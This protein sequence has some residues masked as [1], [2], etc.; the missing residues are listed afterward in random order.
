MSLGRAAILGASVNWAGALTG[1]VV[2]FLVNAALARMIEPSSFASFALATVYS[3]LLSIVV[4]AGFAHAIVQLEERPDLTVPASLQCNLVAG[5]LLIIGSLLLFPIVAS[6]GGTDTALLV[7]AL[8]ATRA[9]TII[10]GSYDALLQRE[11]EFTR[12]AIIR[13][14]ALLISAAGAMAFAAAGHAMY[15]LVAR[16]ALVPVLSAYFMFARMRTHWPLTFRP[17]DEVRAVRRK[18]LSIG[19]SL[20]WVQALETIHQRIDQLLFSKLMPASELA[21]YY[22]ARYVA[23]LPHA[24]VAPATQTVALRVFAAVASE[25][26]KVRRTAQLLQVFVAHAL[27]LCAI[28]IAFAPST[29]VR[30]AYGERWLGLVGILPALALWVVLQPLSRNSSVALMALGKWRGLR[31]AQVVQVI[32]L[33]LAVPV[34]LWLLGPSGA[35]WALSVSTFGSMV[36]MRAAMPAEMRLPSLTYK[37]IGIGALSVTALW[38]ATRSG[39]SDVTAE[40]LRTAAAVALYLVTSVVSD[41]SATLDAIRLIRSHLQKRG[42]SSDVP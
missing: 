25:P 41:L 7:L 3:E 21:I 19:K 20:F 31:I 38:L 14:G 24:A 2:R 15:A 16:E 9:F 23:S 40:L 4:A 42:S 32:I 29:L 33:A 35:A 12:L 22:Q 27:M 30:L 36:A 37:G 1:F 11:L 28:A 18:V 34:L 26:A 39:R 6:N 17:T 8:T 5:F 10:A 13:F